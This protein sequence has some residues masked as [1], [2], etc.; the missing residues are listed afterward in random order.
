M[1]TERILVR[2]S[3]D[4]YQ[5]I[6]KACRLAKCVYNVANYRI[7]QTFIKEGEVVSHS[8]VDKELR[9]VRTSS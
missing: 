7:R 2:P 1:R 8:K 6:R 3:D 5:A 4:N 9:K